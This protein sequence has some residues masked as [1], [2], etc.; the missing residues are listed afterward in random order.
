MTNI[1][2]LKRLALACGTLL[3][4]FNCADVEHI[5]HDHLEMSRT[6]PL[7]IDEPQ[8]KLGNVLIH[9]SFHSIYRLESRVTYKLPPADLAPV[10]QRTRKIIFET[11]YKDSIMV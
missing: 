2:L 1:K 11:A 9:S 7:D 4:W 8:M 5:V 3:L 6:L 10:S